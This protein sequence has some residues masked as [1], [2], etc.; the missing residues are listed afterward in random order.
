MPGDV[1]ADKNRHLW[2]RKRG[3]V[4]TRYA[5]SQYSLGLERN[6]G[7]E[8]QSICA[9]KTKTFASV[10]VPED[11]L[12][13]QRYLMGRGLKLTCPVERFATSAVMNPSQVEVAVVVERPA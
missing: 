7:V 10:F 3:A 13:A 4:G 11:E 6:F 8:L 5:T 9:T 2:V 12:D 1:V